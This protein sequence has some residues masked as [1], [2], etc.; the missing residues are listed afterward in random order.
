[1]SR[2]SGNV[3][4]LF[5]ALATL[6]LSHAPM[7]AQRQA[8]RVLEIINGREA[9]SREVLVKFRDAPRPDQVT[10]IRSLADADSMRPVGRTG[11]Q[12]LQSRSMSA[13][14]L[15]QRLANHPDVLYAEPNYVV[16]TFAEPNEP[17]FPQLWGLRNIGQSVNS[18][19]PGVAGADIHAVAAW[20]VS[21]GSAAQV[22]AV[23]DTGID[24]THP[25]LA[26][27][28]W[29]APSAFQVTIEGT[30]I[31]CPA[32]TH[33]FN[34]VAR[35]CDPMDDHEHGTHVS[36]TI[37]ASGN[38]AFG[39][40]GVNWITQLM[41]IKF[42]DENGSGSIADAISRHRL[43]DSGQAGVRFDVWRKRSS[44]LRELG[45]HRLLAGAPGR[46]QQC[47]R[48]RHAVCGCRRQ[49]RHQQR[50]LP[51]LSCEL[52]RAKHHFGRRDHQ[53]RRPS[54]VLELRR[55]VCSSGSPR[56]RH[57]FHHARQYLR[58]PQRDLDGNPACVRR[59]S[60][61]AC[62]SARSTRRD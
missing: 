57:F 2:P 47:Q 53:H 5:V 33:G 30:T 54:V 11:V 18:G 52:R 8:G 46:N 28:M 12:R 14:A 50:Y 22:V 9:L 13:I 56:N 32:G 26:A 23:V 10:E 17:A 51:H 6:L 31:T 16:R 20:D 41:G 55:L 21:S 58:L 35:T 61:R 27:N 44:A 3:T 49:Q 37:G 40:V 25:D 4:L 24:Y 36:G 42:L 34:V 19:F 60:T 62:R 1:M 43:R 7:Q 59:R 29:S 38:N 45:Q 15:L 48:Q 39:V